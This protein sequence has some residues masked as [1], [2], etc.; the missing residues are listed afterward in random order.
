MSDEIQQKIFKIIESTDESVPMEDLYK[1]LGGLDDELFRQ[2][3]RR[4]VTQ[5]V[6]EITW[7]CRFG[8]PS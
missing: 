4:L 5:G 3:L 2:A 1:Q 8:I 6:I 7:E